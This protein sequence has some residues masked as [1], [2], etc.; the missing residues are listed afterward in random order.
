VLLTPEPVVEDGWRWHVMADP[1][2]N[3][4]WALQPPPD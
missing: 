3:E 4:L 1:D 2:G